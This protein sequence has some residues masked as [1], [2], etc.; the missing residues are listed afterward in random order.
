MQEEHEAGAVRSNSLLKW[1]GSLI[2]PLFARAFIMS[3]PHPYEYTRLLYYYHF[4]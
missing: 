2:S 1:K 4:P 3:S